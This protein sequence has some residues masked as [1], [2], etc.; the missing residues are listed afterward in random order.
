VDDLFALLAHRDFKRIRSLDDRSAA[1]LIK[2]ALN[3]T[4]AYTKQ[5]IAT[6]GADAVVK[7]S[8]LEEDD[9]QKDWRYGDAKGAEKEI[10]EM[11]REAP[12]VFEQ[13]LPERNRRWFAA[14]KRGLAARHNVMVLVG[15]LHLAGNDGLIEMLRREGFKPEQMY[16]IDRP[17]MLKTG[18]DHQPQR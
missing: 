17:K 7:E 6:R 1:Q 10:A 12:G 3:A 2:P 5:E 14:I 13:L 18:A 11:K 8:I 15:A 9:S 4:L 16:G